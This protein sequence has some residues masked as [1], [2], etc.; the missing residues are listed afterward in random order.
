[1][2]SLEASKAI[3]PQIGNPEYV[4]TTS[5]TD[6]IEQLESRKWS[7]IFFAP[8]ACRYSAASRPMPGAI[9]ST[10][11]WSL[12]QYKDLV[13]QHQGDEIQIVETQEERLTVSLLKQALEKARETKL[14]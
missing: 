8:G 13:R 6:F 14:Q 9:S 1:M 5:D 4:P 3:P 7:V 10:R 12:E 2:Q 11:D